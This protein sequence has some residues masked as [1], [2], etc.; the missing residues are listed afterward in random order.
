MC[1]YHSPACPRSPHR[2]AGLAGRTAGGPSMRWTISAPS[3]RLQPNQRTYP[4]LLL[5]ARRRLD[6]GLS[7]VVD[8]DAAVVSK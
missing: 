4:A 1:R 7:L 6:P 2:N 8:E 3:C 5:V